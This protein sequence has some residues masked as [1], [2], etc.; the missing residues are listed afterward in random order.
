[1]THYQPQKEADDDNSSQ[2]HVDIITQWNAKGK[3]L[4]LLLD[5]AAAQKEAQKKDDDDDDDDFLRSV[6][7]TL[8]MTGRFVSETSAKQPSSKTGPR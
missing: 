4:Y 6:W 2:E 3:F 1:M 7:I 5:N 8:G